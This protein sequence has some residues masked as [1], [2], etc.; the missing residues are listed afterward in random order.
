MQYSPMDKLGG[1]LNK[2]LKEAHKDGLA[3]PN[4]VSESI[5]DLGDAAVETG[6]AAMR[7]A[8]HK[9][10]EVTKDVAGLYANGAAVLR[11]R[12]A[13]QPMAAVG[14]ALAAGAIFAGLMFRK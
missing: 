12:V 5:H 14:I 4:G 11:K 7:E 3:T 1:D 6:K 13:S 2:P 10:D 8:Q 9:A